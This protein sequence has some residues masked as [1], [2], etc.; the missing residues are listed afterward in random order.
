MGDEIFRSSGLE[1]FSITRDSAICF[2]GSI[3][4]GTPLHKNYSLII[5]PVRGSMY[6]YK[7]L[8]VGSMK[9]VR[10][11][12]GSNVVFMEKSVQHGCTLDLSECSSV[13]FEYGTFTCSRNSHGMITS[14]SMVNLIMP[15]ASREYVPEY[16][17]AYYPGGGI[18]PHRNWFTDVK[19]SDDSASVKPRDNKLPV[20]CFTYNKRA[21]ETMVSHLVIDC[22]TDWL[23]FESNAISSACLRSI[24]ING[25]LYGDGR[26]FS[27]FCS[28]LEKVTF[29]QYTV[30][31]PT[32]SYEAHRYLLGAFRDTGGRPCRCFDRS[33]YDRVF[34][35]PP[36]NWSG[37][38]RKRLSQREL[39]DIAVAVMRSSPELFGNREMYERYL[40]THKR[41]AMHILDKLPEENSEFLRSFFDE[42]LAALAMRGV[43][44]TDEKDF[45]EE[46]L[47]VLRKAAEELSYLL[48]RG[49]PMTSA[50]KYTG[51][52]YKFSERQRNA[53]AMT[54]SPLQGIAERKS[55]Q[56]TDISGET[57]Y[58]DGLDVI[59]A[60]ETAFSHSVLF[61][62]MDG[63]VRDLADLDGEYSLI[64]QTDTAIKALIRALGDLKAAKAVICLD[65]SVSH[66]GRLKKRIC[67]LAEIIPFE[68]EVLNEYAVDSV[69]KAKPLI[70][71][72][73]ADVL[74]QC[75][76]WFNLSRYIADSYFD[77]CPY[78]DMIPVFPEA[79][80]E[81]TDT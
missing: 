7:V 28:R 24:T 67:E 52:H 75:D 35:E 64:P 46:K 59:T 79:D 19:I 4:I 58:I 51:D 29:N 34:T 6:D 5:K 39:I 70:A 47:P 14:Y 44:P 41:Y 80:P 30:Y 9:T 26:L 53:L 38:G 69:L 1:G 21:K 55:R 56:V 12:K 81:N 65:K 8:L 31:I 16:V 63:T 15:C 71:S 32:A 13:S 68:L 10:F 78:V 18:Y 57:I 50:V 76:R 60:L 36:V 22:G 45:S 3:F 11:R 33:M 25:W 27:D 23:R 2:N 48:N 54:I 20:Y 72:S 74:D 49:Y 17:D 42:K 37:S 61:S 73:D 66:S 62:C 43:L 40:I 77:T